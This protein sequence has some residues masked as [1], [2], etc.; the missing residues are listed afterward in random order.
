MGQYQKA[1]QF[2]TPPSLRLKMMT[3]IYY[4]LDLHLVVEA[5]LAGE[6][7]LLHS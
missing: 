4:R 5:N 1:M 2:L 6:S 3:L 7:F